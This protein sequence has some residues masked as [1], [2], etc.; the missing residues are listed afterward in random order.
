MLAGSIS[1]GVT[2]R[3]RRMMIQ[4]RLSPWVRVLRILHFLSLA[5]ITVWFVPRGWP[6]LRSPVFWPA[7]ICGQHSLEIFCLGV[8]HHYGGRGG[9]D[10]V[11]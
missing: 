1:S 11:V 8:G 10:F 5:M 3:T 6:R 7:I 9:I 4:R 2:A